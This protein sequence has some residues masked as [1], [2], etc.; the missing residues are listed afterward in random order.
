MAI[1]EMHKHHI[2]ASITLAQGLLESGAGRSTLTKYSNNHFGI[3]CGRTWQ[4]EKTYHNDDRPNECFREYDNPAQSF[5]DHS[6]FLVKNGRYASLFKLDITDYK[7]WAHGLRKAG[8]ATNPN[9][10]K[11]LISLIEQYEL[12]QY[13]RV[14]PE[15]QPKK[16]KVKADA[17]RQEVKPLETHQTYLANGLVYVKVQKSDTWKTLSKGLNISEKKLRKY[18][19]LYKGYALKEGDILYL[20]QKHKK[21][22]KGNVTHVVKPGE[23]MHSVSQKYGIRLKNLYKLNRMDEESPSPE[24]GDV[25]RLR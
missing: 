13:D 19:D 20:T 23:S 11:L 3:K 8:Y 16:E 9:Y 7:G 15:K 10:G 22:Q 24:A 21:A 18:N 2:P 17:K 25:L 4:G 1:T 12:H 5:E 6:L 14:K